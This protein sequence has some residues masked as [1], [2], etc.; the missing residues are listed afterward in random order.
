MTSDLLT[1]YRGKVD[2][3]IHH[4]LNSDV[5]DV[6]KMLAYHFGFEN[7]HSLGKMLR[8]TLCLLSTDAV[9]R[10][11][12]NAIPA[13]AALELFH[14]FT[15]IHDDIE[16]K[17]SYRHNQLTVWKKYGVEQAIN[18]GDALCILTFHEAAKLGQKFPKSTVLQ[19][20][21]QITQAAIEITKGQEQDLAFEK[22]VEVTID[23]YLCMIARKTGA[24]IEASIRIGALLGNANART[25]KYLS[26]YAKELGRGFQI[27]DDYLGIFGDAKKTG[28]SIG[29][30]IKRR[31]KTFP[32]IHALT[33]ANET[34]KKILRKLFLMNEKEL[35]DKEVIEVL[36]IVEKVKSKEKT[37]ETLQICYT[38][39]LKEI[40][41]A[42]LP[43]WATKD[44]I[45]LA[46]FFFER[47]Y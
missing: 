43:Q 19:I 30:D 20:I 46:E 23:E 36:D 27:M 16:D 40:Q 14:N 29:K 26:Y 24:L 9:S 11:W 25:L 3:Y 45:F 1:R 6:Y 22:R 47:Q 34:D 2:V 39:A 21:N 32:I 35:T 38:T 44:Y 18:A 42:K 4:L 37:R 12:E 28:K 17:D 5:S 31:K 10:Q 13:A 15:L 7:I 41:K 33:N 8:P